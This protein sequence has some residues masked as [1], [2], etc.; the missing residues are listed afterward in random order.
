MNNTNIERAKLFAPVVVRMGLS[1][2]FIWFGLQ[3]LTN[4]EIWTGLIPQSIINISGLSAITFV[5]LNGIFEVIVSLC[6]LIGFFTRTSALLLTLHLF[7]IILIVGYNDVGVRDFG[8][9]MA[10][11]SIFLNGA[12]IWCA[13][14]FFIKNKLTTS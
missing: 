9:A 4:A 7:N 2:V 13:D 3:Q 5:Y 1:L 11:I 14:K 10:G 8:L 6:L 12:D